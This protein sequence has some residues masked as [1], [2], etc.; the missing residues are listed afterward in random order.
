MCR[1]TLDALHLPCNGP[2]SMA[3][4][5]E[6]FGQAGPQ[7]QGGGKYRSKYTN[8]NNKTNDN[9]HNDHG[10]HHENNDNNDKVGSGWVCC[11]ITTIRNTGE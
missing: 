5:S 9:D 7:V 1:R 4:S 3:G 11:D 8:T 6:S 2:Q 10:D